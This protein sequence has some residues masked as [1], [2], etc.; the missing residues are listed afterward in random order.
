MASDVA[1]AGP[2]LGLQ[3][4]L[5]AYERALILEAIGACGG[6]QGQA[7]SL[8]GVRRTT[9]NDKLK[10]HRICDRDAEPPAGA[11]RIV[12][13]G[14]A[15][16][17]HRWV[18]VLAPGSRLEIRGVQGHVRVSGVDTAQAEVVAVRHGNP[19][20]GEA[21]LSILEHAGGATMWVHHLRGARPG[22]CRPESRM[23]V[24]FQVRLPRQAALATR[25]S[26]GHVEVVGV[27]GDVDVGTL[28]G[29]VIL[30]SAPRVTAPPSCE[31][32]RA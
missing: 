25:I 11:R 21:E 30:R 6:H 26:T 9:L 15:P 20:Q 28:R 17:A 27:S 14:G 1:G 24:E 16:D 29:E 8:L 5:E 31:T 2:L 22:Q 19:G 10:R 32:D 12:L 3:D 4:R 23:R 13:G 18:G 7:A